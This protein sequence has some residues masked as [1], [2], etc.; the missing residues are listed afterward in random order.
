MQNELTEKMSDQTSKVI[1][2]TKS[3]H[4]IAYNKGLQADI[5]NT[6]QIVDALQKRQDT[7]N[8]HMDEVTRQNEAMNADLKQIGPAIAKVVKAQNNNSDILNRAL[9]HGFFVHT[10]DVT[11]SVVKE[12]KELTGFTINEFLQNEIIKQINANV[13]EA[14]Q[15][16]ISAIKEA[17]V[18]EEALKKETLLIQ[19]FT[20]LMSVL[21]FELGVIITIGIVLPGWWKLI[22]L[23]IAVGIFAILNHYLKGKEDIDGI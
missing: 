1:E 6:R 22:G 16:K 10:T 11:K 15:A 20:L 2:I 7:A 5:T 21:V 12:F 18:A 13:Y 8:V 3:T 14:K 23:V 4:D 19:M 9:V 17:Q